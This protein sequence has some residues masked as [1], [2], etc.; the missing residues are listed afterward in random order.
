MLIF[1]PVEI[2]YNITEKRLIRF[3]SIPVIENEILGK[4]KNFLFQV[5]VLHDLP[6][7]LSFKITLNYFCSVD[8]ALQDLKSS[9][10]DI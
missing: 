8:F 5:L 2:T 4:A 6:T 9:R 3:S 7:V 10:Y 1:D